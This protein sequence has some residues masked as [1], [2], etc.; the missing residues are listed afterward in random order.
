[1]VGPY[2]DNLKALQAR[3]AELDLALARLPTRHRRSLPVLL[4]GLALLLFSLAKLAASVAAA[5]PV[6]A[7]ARQLERILARANEV[8]GHRLSEPRKLRA[9]LLTGNFANIEP[10]AE[11]EI[12]IVPPCF[13]TV[14][15][16]RVLYQG[17]GSCREGFVDAADASLDETPRCFVDVVNRHVLVADGD[18]WAHLELQ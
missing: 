12:R 18:A 15:C 2:R 5:A 9:R 10:D 11:C 3:S 4:L 17:S 6:Y 16:G 7:K 8:W 13:A 14:E 1:V